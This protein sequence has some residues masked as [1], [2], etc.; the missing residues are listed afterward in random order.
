M[1]TSGKRI[2]TFNYDFGY[3]MAVVA[4]DNEIKSFTIGNNLYMTK[5]ISRVVRVSPL[6][7]VEELSLTA[8]QKKEIALLKN[9]DSYLSKDGKL[10]NQPDILKLK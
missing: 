2:K 8:D 9:I 3:T 6:D 5:Y 7:S 4:I 10:L 1:N